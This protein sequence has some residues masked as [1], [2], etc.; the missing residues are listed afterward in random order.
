M[1]RLSDAGSIPAR[2]IRK[3]PWKSLISGVFLSLGNVN[4]DFIIKRNTKYHVM[5]VNYTPVKQSAATIGGGIPLLRY[6][7]R[8][9]RKSLF[10][11]NTFSAIR[12]VAVMHLYLASLKKISIV[13]SDRPI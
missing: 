10:S 12:K 3:K 7:K 11:S 5:R 1:D 6:M 13:E 4:Y 2:S 8:Q 9:V